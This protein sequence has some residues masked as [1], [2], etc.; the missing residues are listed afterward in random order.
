MLEPGEE[1]EDGERYLMYHGTRPEVAA[2]I[3][4]GRFRPSTQGLLGPGVYVSRNIL[5]SRKYGSTIL[6]VMVSVGK[7]CQADKHPDMIPKG[8]GTSA[9]WHDDGGFDTA[10]VPAN[11]PASVFVGAHYSEGIVEEDCVWDPSRVKVMGRAEDKGDTMMALIRWCFEEDQHR[12][13]AQSET[14]GDCWVPF[15]QLT[16]FYIESHYLA[17]KRSAGQSSIL[18]VCEESRKLFHLHTG[19]QYRV[20]F[21]RMMQQNEQ[22]SYERRIMRVEPFKA[23]VPQLQSGIRRLLAQSLARK[24]QDA[25]IILQRTWRGRFSR[26]QNR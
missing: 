6:E 16:S 13:S 21:D 14:L 3:E 20:H 2:L 12:I 1:P 24:C 26:N 23:S 4:Q 5:K 17:W 9:P 19:T 25:S 15:S 10:W 7:V 11:C 8:Y 22:T 18:V